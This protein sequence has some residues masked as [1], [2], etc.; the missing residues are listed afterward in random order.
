MSK[1]RDRLAEL[2]G[3]ISYS[4]RDQELLLRA[5]THGS[6][7]DGKTGSGNYQR[8]EFLGDRVL[9]L[10]A[11]ERL[12]EQFDD[13]EGALARRLNGLVRKE[14]CARA[15]ERAGLGEALR[16]SKSTAADNGRTNTRI[17]GDACEA[18]L[19]AIYLDGGLDAARAF[20]DRFWAEELPDIA[21]GLRDP[22]TRLQEWALERFTANPVY[23]LIE[24]AGPDHRPVFNVE[25]RVGDLAP[26]RGEGS[27]KQRAER[28]AAKALLA[29]EGVRE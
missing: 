28:T 22:K 26:E 20:F 23:K 21:D 29:R 3:R 2:E 10:V 9:G 1:K 11:A 8:L 18:L 24:R 15:A 19:A 17:L 7:G 14:A 6:F 16:M 27:S 13:D 12:V 25:V 5:L 4:F